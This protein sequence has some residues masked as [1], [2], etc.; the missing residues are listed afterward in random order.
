MLHIKLWN[1]RTKWIP[2]KAGVNAGSPGCKAV[3]VAAPVVAT[4]ALH[5]LKIRWIEDCVGH[6]YYF[7][8]KKSLKQMP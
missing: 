5:F 1:D 7:D 6:N 3:A 8:V 4:V 2:L